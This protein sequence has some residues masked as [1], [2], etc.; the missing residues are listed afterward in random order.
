MKRL[1]LF[2]AFFFLASAAPK[3][4]P[5]NPVGAPFCGAVPPKR[6]VRAV[7]L[8]TI[9]GL[10]WPHG[11]SRDASG[12][13]RQKKELTDI[14]DRLEAAGV[15]TVLLQ[16]RVRGTLIYPSAFEPWD[17]CLSGVP[18]L[19]PGYDALAFAT[20]ECHKRGMEIQ[21]WVVAVP[22]GK[23]TSKGCAELRR[24]H[25]GLVKRIGD[26]G[27]MDPENGLTGDY[28]ASLCAEITGRYDI[29]G[30]HLDYIRYPEDWK[31]KIPK[32][33]AREC[34]TDIVRKV[35]AA[36][37][38]RKKWV[39]VSCSPVGKYD[40][41]PRQSSRGWNAYARVCQDVRGWLRAGLVDEIFPMMYF[42]G[43]DFYP[44]AMDWQQHSAGRTVVPGLGVYF[45]SEGEKNWPLEVITREMSVLRNFGMGHA[46]FRSGFFTANTKGIY[47]FA[48]KEFD[49]AHALV[50]AM[51]WEWA[52]APDAPLT[53]SP[54]T[55]SGTLSWSGARDNSDGPYLNYNLYASRTFPVDVTDAR[56]LVLPHTRATRVRA[57][58]DGTYYAVTATDRYGNESPARQQDGVKP[59]VPS[60]PAP[61]A[62]RSVPWLE[63]DGK[64]LLT[65][66]T[67][68][69]ASDL[70][71]IESPAGRPVKD[72]FCS[73]SV[74]V[75][76][77]EEGVYVLR[78]VGRKGVT[79]RIG[80]FRIRRGGGK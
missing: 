30:I 41:L 78:S 5:Q 23:W 64:R 42:Q 77:V 69:N 45:M 47:D 63:C 9:G 79:H 2:S 72:V 71:Q 31:I 14:L 19:S 61:P 28:I 7:W 29:D 73:R 17:G 10:D 62:K 40:D 38:S 55:L 53:L 43:N 22:V 39:K 68:I 51:T 80:F 37:K 52:K 48:R 11:Y 33:R 58:F 44:F 27:Y 75:S 20:E 18:G 59:A 25:P 34:V 50:P 67:Q 56:N 6:E 36:V 8:A 57:P 13:R 26:Y 12:I 1:V 74:D 49:F 54:D 21:A 32:D 70:L 35:H 46:Y 4:Q 15:N 76:D 65:G 3:A 16:T 24:K 66:R 60:L